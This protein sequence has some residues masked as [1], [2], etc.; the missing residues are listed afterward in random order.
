MDA[1]EINCM[2]VCVIFSPINKCNVSKVQKK[3]NLHVMAS[4]LCRDVNPVMFLVSL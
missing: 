3:I 4:F 1:A 2:C